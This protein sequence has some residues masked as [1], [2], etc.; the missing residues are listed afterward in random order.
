MR[1][2]VQNERYLGG[3]F[4]IVVLVVDNEHVREVA[5]TDKAA[6]FVMLV[7]RGSAA[8][9]PDCVTVLGT[10]WRS[11]STRHRTYRNHSFLV[12]KV[13]FCREDLRLARSAGMSSIIVTVQ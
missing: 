5:L 1:L 10:G 7:E 6:Y 13:L 12:F 3:I 9:L 11:A 2:L 4:A 8:Q